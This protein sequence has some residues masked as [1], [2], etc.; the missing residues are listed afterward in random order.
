[1]SGALNPAAERQRRHRAR[2]K[3]GRFVMRVEGC[4]EDLNM[5]I[6][7]GFLDERNVHDLRACGVAVAHFLAAS[8]KHPIT[9]DTKGEPQGVE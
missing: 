1:M 8:R 3:N 2:R 5:L 7:D 9:R 6:V 4:E